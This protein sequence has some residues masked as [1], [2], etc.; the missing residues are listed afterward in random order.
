[1]DVTIELRPLPSRTSSL[2]TALV[3]PHD[4]EES[5]YY[6][7]PS[8]LDE[9]LRDDITYS[10]RSSISSNQTASDRTGP[11]RILGN[12]YSK[13]GRV[14]IRSLRKKRVKNL[15]TNCPS[16]PQSITVWRDGVEQGNGSDT[17]T[18]YT[19]HSTWSSDYTMSNLVGA[20]RVIGKLYSRAGSSFEKGL[21]RLAYS[22]GIGSFAKLH[23]IYVFLASVDPNENEKG[24]ELLLACARLD[25]VTVQIE[26]FEE[27]VEH[28][29][30]YPLN[31]CSAFR[32][33]FERRKE[34]SDVT[35]F[36]WKRPGVEY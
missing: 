8:Y 23:Y 34:I 27:V 20:G 26:T 16:S 29:V 10:Y 2:E 25:D 18:I 21:G 19:Y 28:F 14:L 6:P 7:T 22:A 5:D 35:T 9:L 13:A 3:T 1:M 11:G 4:D 33:V 36:S 30:M 32:R 17:S 31:V 15:D 12:V 24:C